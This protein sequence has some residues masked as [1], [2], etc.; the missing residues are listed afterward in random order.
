MNRYSKVWRALQ[1]SSPTIF[2]VFAVG[3]VFLTAYLAARSGMK[4]GEIL[5]E[6]EEKEETNTLYYENVPAIEVGKGVS[7]KDMVVNTWHCYIPPALSGVATSAAI[8]FSRHLSQKQVIA[9]AGTA[10]VISERYSQYR[11]G[12]EELIDDLENEED[13]KKIRE[14]ISRRHELGAANQVIDIP[15]C[16]DEDL[17]LF[18]ETISGNFF[19][20]TIERV[21]SAEYHANR[22]LSLRGHVPF[23][24]WLDFLGIKE[25]CRPIDDNYIWDIDNL[26][27]DWDTCWLD[28]DHHTI[29]TESGETATVINYPIEPIFVNW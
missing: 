16:N 20:S 1:K 11:K 3:G 29:I 9:L 14:E 4:A 23:N 2:S 13:K 10:A 17:P 22:N 26:L 5:R 24:E 27:T 12:F 6:L 21:Q 25:H 8:I 7:V 28:F 19:R 15:A 18:Y